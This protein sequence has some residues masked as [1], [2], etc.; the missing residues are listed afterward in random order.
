MTE[1]NQQKKTGD[2]PA[3]PR[4]D[5]QRDKAYDYLAKVIRTKGRFEL[6]DASLASLRAEGVAEAALKK[7][8]ALKNKEFRTQYDFVKELASRLGA[9]ELKQYQT[10]VLLHSWKKDQGLITNYTGTLI[11]ADAW[12]DCYFLWCLER[13]AMIYQ[14]ET[15]DGEDWYS[16]GVDILLPSQ[17]QDGSWAEKHGDIADTSFALLFL[18]RANLA[19]DLT[20]K[21]QALLA[22]AQAASDR[23]AKK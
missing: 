10:R 9:E 1:G 2:P 17:K 3:N 22:A 15:I 8:A 7:M 12:G 13:V 20:D 6:T 23:P 21:L 5:E 14:R 4:A 18:T 11:R 19:R 16:W